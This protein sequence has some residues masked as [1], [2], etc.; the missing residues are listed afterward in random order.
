[1]VEA[2]L[3]ADCRKAGQQVENV[4]QELKQSLT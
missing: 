1:M 4:Q 3:R 2:S